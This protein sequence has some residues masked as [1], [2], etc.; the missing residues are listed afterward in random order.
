MP[1]TCPRPPAASRPHAEYHHVNGLC[2]PEAAH[3]YLRT[4]GRRLHAEE[5]FD[6]KGTKPEMVDEE[7]K[8]DDF[9]QEDCSES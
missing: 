3:I 8:Q 7:V 9:G 1:K 5:M 6:R 2:T 4:S